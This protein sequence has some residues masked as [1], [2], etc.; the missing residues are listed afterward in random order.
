[1]KTMEQHRNTL[2]VEQLEQWDKQYLWHPFTQ[3]K[4]YC[5]EKPL[6]IEKGEGSFLIDIYGN[7]YLDGVSSLWVTIHGHGR[8]EINR[9]IINQ[10]KEISHSTLLGL[11]NVPAIKLAK[12]LV[13]ITPNGLDKVFYSDG[14]STAVE[15]ALKMAFQYWQQTSP[16]KKEK[17]KFISLN[18]AYHGDTLGAV[19]VGGID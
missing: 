16:I 13:E 4:D 12:K 19:S 1:M 14:G 8:E 10:A 15:I 17:H 2:D 11:S 9:A 7:K 18:L 3:M 5:D 6:I